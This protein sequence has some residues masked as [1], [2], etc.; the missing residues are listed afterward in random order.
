[1]LQSLRLELVLIDANLMLFK[2]HK[3]N[4]RKS[5]RILNFEV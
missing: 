4:N 2:N 1:M 3:T 5:V